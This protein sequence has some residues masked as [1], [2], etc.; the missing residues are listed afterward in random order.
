LNGIYN[1]CN[2][3]HIP[4]KPFYERLCQKRQIPPIQWDPTLTSLHQGN[5]RVSNQ[6]I[7]TA[8]FAFTHPDY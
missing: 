8:G 4:R 5:R 1:L 6:K 3:F 7:K 2:D